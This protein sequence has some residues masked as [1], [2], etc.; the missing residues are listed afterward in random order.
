MW[1]RSHRA[2]KSGV[3]ALAIGLLMAVAAVSARSEEAKWQT[4]RVDE[5]VNIRSGPSLGAQRLGRLRPGDAV[6]AREPVDGWRQVAKPDAPD[7]PVGYVFATLLHP[8]ADSSSPALASGYD[9]RLTPS[10]GLRETYDDN[11]LFKGAED[12]EHAVSPGL[13]IALGSELATLSLSSSAEILTYGSHSEYDRTNQRH[14]LAL[15]RSLDEHFDLALRALMMADSSFEASL[16]ETGIVTTRI[17]RRIYSLAPGLGYRPD[18]R[19]TLRLASDLRAYRHANRPSSDADIRGAG[20]AWENRLAE[21]GTTLLARSSYTDTGY[22]HGEQK[23]TAL[24]AGL[25][26]SLSENVRWTALAGPTRTRSAFDSH[27]RETTGDST[28]LGGELGLEFSGERSSLTLGAIQDE[29]ST[30]LG[31]NAFRRMLRAKLE[32]DLSER[33]TASLSGSSTK[34]QSG[35]YVQKSESLARHAEPALDYALDKDTHLLLGLSSTTVVNQLQQKT[36][37]QKRVYLELRMAL[38]TDLN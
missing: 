26:D 35:A 37:E 5:V 15:A 33:L 31:E 11:V 17:P 3:L 18:E 22:A 34:T 2:A 24:L 16:Q 29:T 4:M 28:R 20:L 19:T 1:T 38:P 7:R 27:G 25:K 23:G 10:L 6:L 9:I 36:Q 13:D 14:S 21:R 8:T 32:Y 12:M 30:L